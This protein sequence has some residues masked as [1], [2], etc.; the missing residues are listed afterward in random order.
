VAEI[1]PDALR[2][3]IADEVGMLSARMEKG[4]KVAEARAGRLEGKLDH[5]VQQSADSRRRMYDKIEDVAKDVSDIR[6]NVAKIDGRVTA[7]ERRVEEATPTLQDYIRTKA[8]VEGAGGLGRFLW[9]L[10][11]IVL[12]IAATLYAA[13]RDGV[14]SG[15]FGK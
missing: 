1:E 3:V 13:W 5:S 10:G 12:G 15:L 2:K 4:F 14:I 11:G 8:K 7:V 6:V 9:W